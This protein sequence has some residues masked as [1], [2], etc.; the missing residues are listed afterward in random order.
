M[1][2]RIRIAL[3]ASAIAALAPSLAFAQGPMTIERIHNG[4]LAAPDVKITDVD[5]KTSPLVGGYAGWIYDDHL[6][7]GGGGYWLAS[8]TRD[9]EMAYG[10]LIVQWLTGL[11]QTVGFGAKALIG[12]GEAQLAT[13]V[14]IQ[15]VPIPIYDPRLGL[16]NVPGI[17]ITT[18]VPRPTTVSV[19]ER[20]G[21][22]V[23]EPE[24]SVF[25]RLA[26]H[27]RL[28][29]GVG[30]RATAADR[31]LNDSRLRGA[32]GSVAVQIGGGS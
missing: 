13:N 11:D 3:I 16:P 25:V 9:R 8:G 6:F 29:G 26:S 22:F 30:Y 32:T 15:P 12:G 4:L 31:G 21:F 2:A 17:P 18:L 7:V 1:S 24:L 27:V 28:T 20:N 23:A 14:T 5:H 19:L 10:G